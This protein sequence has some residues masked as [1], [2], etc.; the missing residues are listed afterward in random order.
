MNSSVC[1]FL[2]VFFPPARRGTD[3]DS[4]NPMEEDY[5]SRSFNSY[6]SGPGVLMESSRKVGGG[7]G[8]PRRPSTVI[9]LFVD[10]IPI[11]LNKVYACACRFVCWV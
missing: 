8:S 1:F 9:T 2:L 3:E 11:S 10:N 4:W 5:N 6:V 7:A